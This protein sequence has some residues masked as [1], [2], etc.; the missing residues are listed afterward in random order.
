[1][2]VCTVCNRQYD[3]DSNR[4]HCLDKCNTCQTNER[5]RKRKARLVAI[6]GGQCIRCGYNKCIQALDFHHRNESQKEFQIG[7]SYNVSWERLFI[8]AQ[9][10]DLVCKNC[11]TEIHMERHAA[12][13]LADALVLHTS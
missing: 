6:F 1:M 8:E 7:K 3:Y 2:R 12:G 5:G 10:C 9:K 11:H 4:G 13:R